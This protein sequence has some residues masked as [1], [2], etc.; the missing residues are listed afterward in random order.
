MLQTSHHFLHHRRKL[1][2]SF[3]PNISPLGPNRC[4]GS[5]NISARRKWLL[6]QRLHLQVSAVIF[7]LFPCVAAR[8]GLPLNCRWCVGGK[9]TG[10]AAFE[11]PH[12]RGSL[13]LSLKHRVVKLVVAQNS[14]TS[15][16]LH[17]IAPEC[18]LPGLRNSELDFWLPIPWVTQRI[19]QRFPQV[20]S[21]AWAHFSREHCLP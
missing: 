4:L 3:W 19:I 21:R 11:L 14:K 5:T 16:L 13:M 18:K 10:E 15:V 6:K 20:S 12:S 8:R 9:N 7:P 1:H 2:G 17:V